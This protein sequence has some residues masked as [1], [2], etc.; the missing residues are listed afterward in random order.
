MR[1]V[2]RVERLQ[3]ELQVGFSDLEGAEQPQIQV[4]DAR[5]AHGVAPHIAEPDFG[6]A[7]ERRRIE[8]RSVAADLPEDLDVLLDLVGRLLVARHVQRRA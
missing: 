7:R 4:R 1:R 8:V 5:P 6:D 2:G 3:A